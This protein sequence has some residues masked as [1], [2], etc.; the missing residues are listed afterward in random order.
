MSLTISNP[1]LLTVLL[2][3]RILS[4][5]NCVR[6]EASNSSNAD[7]EGKMLVDLET[8]YS[9]K[10]RREILARIMVVSDFSVHSV[11]R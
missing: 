10:L 8:M 6:I 2:N 1:S 9:G 7:L 11:E 4:I 5:L 3:S